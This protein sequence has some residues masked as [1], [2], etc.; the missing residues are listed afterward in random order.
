MSEQLS[1]VSTPAG[2]T[3]GRAYLASRNQ[4]ASPLRLN[5]RRALT[6]ARQALSPVE[7]AVLDLVE[8][9]G[10]ALDR[11]AARTGRPLADVT[12][13]YREALRQLAI[14]LESC[15]NDRETI[16]RAQQG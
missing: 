3:Y 10:F 6:A 12:A 1:H 2:Q 11:I 7:A 13:I 15:A 4:E 9:K 5:S 8:G 14:D 16:W